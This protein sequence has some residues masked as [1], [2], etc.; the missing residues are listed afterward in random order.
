MKHARADRAPNAKA[1][2]RV[3]FGARQPRLH[4]PPRASTVM[5]RSLRKGCFASLENSTRVPYASHPFEHCHRRHTLAA[6]VPDTTNARKLRHR[7]R[8]SRKCVRKWPSS[9]LR[10]VR[11]GGGGGACKRCARA[12][13]HACAGRR[14]SSGAGQWLVHQSAC[15]LAHR[16]RLAIS[17]SFLSMCVS[18]GHLQSAR[19]GEKSIQGGTLTTTTANTPCTGNVPQLPR[20]FHGSACARARV[21]ARRLANEA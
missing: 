17:A 12:C 16:S 14:A 1:A 21:R 9:R 18:S 8:S 19:V 11:W 7:R 15:S 6:F 4:P 2:C 3:E 20:A 10:G 5:R 13:I